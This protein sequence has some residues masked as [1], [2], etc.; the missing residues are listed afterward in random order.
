M[1]MFFGY[2][3]VEYYEEISLKL[4]MYYGA[5]AVNYYHERSDKAQKLYAGASALLR[6]RKDIDDTY[7]MYTDEDK[8]TREQIDKYYRFIGLV[9]EFFHEVEGRIDMD[10]YMKK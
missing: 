3:K 4:S 6:M 2:K 9:H 5:C 1:K 8:I 7:L 10:Y